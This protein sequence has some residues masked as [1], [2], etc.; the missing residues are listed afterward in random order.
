MNLK[1]FGL[2]E[3]LLAAIK[4]EVESKMVYKSLAE[5]V[6][7]ALLKDRLIFLSREEEKHR[8]YLEA[9]YRQR[10][11]GKEIKLPE[12]SEVP[13]PEVD[14]S[15]ERL[16]SEIIE[17]SMKAELAAKEFYESLKDLFQDKKVKAMLLILANMEQGHYDILAKELENLKNFENY[18][19]YWPM[20]HSGP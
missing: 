14:P 4:S 18:D 12:K 2:E 10:F 17:D 1:N 20:M 13:L 6:K 8:V 16:L 7:N 19:T 9:L 15:D 5:R 11:S 3:L